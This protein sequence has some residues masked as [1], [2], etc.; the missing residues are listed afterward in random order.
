MQNED[1]D[2]AVFQIEDLFTI[3]GRGRVA[4]GWIVTGNFQVG[5][6]VAVYRNNLHIASALLKA[7][8][9]LRRNSPTLPHTAF[10]LG[11]I[12]EDLLQPGDEIRTRKD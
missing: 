8:E 6:V 1:T 12:A 3:T 2:A 10:L 5:E 9:S 11:D 7:I 4:V